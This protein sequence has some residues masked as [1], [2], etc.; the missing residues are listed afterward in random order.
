MVIAIIALLAAILLP[1]LK[2]ARLKGRM[3]SCLSNMRQLGIGVYLYADDNNGFMPQNYMECSNQASPPGVGPYY[4]GI[5]VWMTYNA[6]LAVGTVSGLSG[7][8]HTWPYVKSPKVYYC[9]ANPT[10]THWLDASWYGNGSS[11]DWYVRGNYSITPPGKSGFGIQGKGTV[12]NYTYRNGTYPSGNATTNAAEWSVARRLG[13]PDV[14]SRVMLTDLWPG[15]SP[16]PVGT[17]DLGYPEEARTGPPHGTVKTVN[18]L[19]TDG[20][21]APWSLPSGMIPMWVACRSGSCF[22]RSCYGNDWFNQPV[23][24]WLLADDAIR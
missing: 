7:I 2:Q 21:A 4:E 9:P 3:A 10:S 1:A 22:T 11:S 15:Y 13:D 16:P 12:S 20:H 23:A 18:I 8:G 5:H 6:K 14:E 24:W 17:G 19:G